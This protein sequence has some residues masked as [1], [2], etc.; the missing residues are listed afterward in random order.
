MI[1]EQRHAL[2]QPALLTS[3]DA[4]GI[5]ILITLFPVFQHLWNDVWRML[6]VSIHDNHTV[7][8][9]IV[10]ACQHGVL[11]TEVARQVDIADALIV[12]SQLADGLD[13]VVATAV[14]DHQHLPRIVAMGIHQLFQRLVEGRQ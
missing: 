11:L 6:Q 1:V 3:C 4:L 8:R 2:A 14:V 5:D 13:G 12:L 9:S 7:A 10:E